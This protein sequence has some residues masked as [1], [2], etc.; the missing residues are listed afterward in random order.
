MDITKKIV[1]EK[2]FKRHST[3]LIGK[4]LNLNNTEKALFRTVLN[5]GFKGEKICREEIISELG[6]D[7]YNNMNIE[8]INEYILHN[9]IYTQVEEKLKKLFFEKTNSHFNLY[10]EITQLA[11]ELK[12]EFLRGDIEKYLISN[13]KKLERTEKRIDTYRQIFGRIGDEC[14]ANE[15]VFQRVKLDYRQL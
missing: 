7:E 11:F 15:N 12:S 2:T 4:I 1:D 3:N 13:K 8:D 10:E 14:C 9:P 5:I 6:I